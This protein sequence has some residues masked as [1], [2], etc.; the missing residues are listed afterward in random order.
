MN[1]TV[2]SLDGAWALYIAPNKEVR[3]KN[4]YAY[5]A[6]EL[7]TSGFC[8]IEGSVPGN[9]EL[10]M[11]RAGLLP[12]LFFGTNPLL[13]QKEENKH[14]WYVRTFEYDGSDTDTYLLF[15]GIDTYAEIYLNGVLVGKCDN[16]LIAHE[17]SAKGLKKG[18]NELLVHILPTAIEIR[19]FANTTLNTAQAYNFDSINVR[20]A[21]YMFGWDI[22]GRFVSG[23]IWK[24]VSL[25]SKNADRIEEFYIGTKDVRYSKTFGKIVAMLNVFVRL[26]LTEDFTDRYRV[27]INGKCKDKRFSHSF[28]P[29]GAN[30]LTT[31]NLEDFYLWWPRGRGEQDLYDVEVGLYLDDMLC[32]SYSTRLGI[33]TVELD[34][35]SVIDPEKG[36][37]FEFIVNGE[38]VFI[39]GTNWVPLDTF[40]SRNSARLDAAM[41][42][43]DDIGCNMIRCWG[44]NVYEEDRFYE[45]CD[46]KGILV[47]QDFGMGCAIYPQNEEFCRAIS[48]E[49]E[50][51]IKR[52]RSHPCLALWAGDNECDIAIAWRYK[53][54][55]IDPDMN[56]LTRK[57]LPA[58]VAQHDPLRTFLPSSPYVDKY[59][60]ESGLPLSEDH[61][62]G[63]RDYFK[64]SYYANAVSAFAS[65]TGYHGC[66]S[67]ESLK[68]YISPEKLW[69]NMCENGRP[70]D[71][72]AVHA[73]SMEIDRVGCYEYRIGLMN[74][75]VVEIFGEPT[76]DNLS[77]A[78]QLMEMFGEGEE[79]LSEYAKASQISQAEACKYF[80][81]RFRI[82]KDIRG[83]LIWWNILDGWPQI[84]D[85][86]VDYYFIK[87]LAYWYIKTSQQPLCLMFDE[88][89]DGRIALYAVNDIPEDRKISYTVARA[90]D[91]AV[92]MSGKALV[93]KDGLLRLGDI[94]CG[95]DEHEFLLIEW[96]YGDVYGKN[97]FVT[98]IR[99]T[100]YTEYKK[101]LEKNKLG[102]FEGFGG[103]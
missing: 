60:F 5:S 84:S 1:K 68:K 76:K 78:R 45:L 39:L 56:V 97:H 10:D 57:V 4:F 46:E 28:R 30:T 95:E 86:V 41:E 32:D 14:L 52:L 33:R 94:S 2:L 98:N 103:K 3:A 22:M 62:W 48:V 26:E 59:A 6:D 75:Q 31:I 66:P 82:R 15:E 91:G 70:N 74:R 90:S 8:K 29:W 7:E 9:F 77:A 34:R 55:N 96:Q 73:A 35:T 37:K 12:D 24:S 100:S 92:V 54:Q 36:G 101:F 17:F 83:G 80:I 67:P 11:Q 65:E 53:R 85:A 49:A 79:G 47:W 87:K 81:E 19:K 69:G 27:E 102:I 43:V 18:T 51:V 25:I 40:P 16:M 71:E 21:A 61:L 89:V 50:A 42:L 64:G 44:G 88:P 99:G 93:E 58:A 72:W 38:K 63:P 23:G 20:K 13:A